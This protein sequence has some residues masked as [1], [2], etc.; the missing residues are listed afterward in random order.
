[1]LTSRARPVL[2]VMTIVTVLTIACQET[3][4]PGGRQGPDPLPPPPPPVLGS[5]I[6]S[7]PTT[8]A[9]PSGSSRSLRLAGELVYI[10]LPPGSFPNG[11]TI[12]VRDRRSGAVAAAPIVLGGADPFPIVGIAGDTLDIQIALGGS[13]DTLAYISLVPLRRPPVLVRTEP[14]VGKRDV[15]L[16]SVLILVFSEPL[17]RQTLTDTTLQLVLASTPISGTIGVAD[18]TGLAITFTPHQPLDPG[19]KYTL[20][21]SV[22][23]RDQSG[24][25]LESPVTLSF[26]TLSGS[27]APVTTFERRSPH[28]V[29][30]HRSRYRLYPGGTFELE[31]ETPSDTVV[32]T[33]HYTQASPTWIGFTFDDTSGTEVGEAY[34]TLLDSAHLAIAY[35]YVM[36]LANLEEGVYASSADSV[37]PPSFPPQAGQIAFVRNGGIYLV[38]SDGSGL[39]QLTSGP[40]DGYPAWSPDGQRIAFTRATETAPHGGYRDI[41]VMN[42]NGTN[43][44]RRT[45]GGYHGAPSWSPDGRWIV[46]SDLNTEDYLTAP[47]GNSTDLFKLPA[48]EDGSGPIN[49]T[50][51]RGW[52]DYPSWSPDGSRI[53]FSSD[54]AAFDF[55]ANVY[56][57]TPDGATPTLVSGGFVE[58]YFPTWLPD[59]QRLAYTNCPWAF[60]YCSSSAL[61]VMKADGTGVIHLAVTSGF[62]RPSWTPDGQTIVFTLYGGIGWVS[63]D[64]RA[65]GIILANGQFPAWRP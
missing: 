17:D 2:C 37:T 25:A 11:V 23:I 49:L 10:S 42:A 36:I 6:V 52:E 64:G 54:W 47:G 9:L 14:P 24:E 48:I 8:P 26:T 59:G 57:T 27:A 5:L 29:P 45:H 19:A 31:Y 40:S 62:N 51:R 41:F 55:V 32:Y 46:F 15:P 56:V 33:G 38:N 7:N 30:S 44:V 3:Q 58:D 35:N 21:A 13:S 18:T 60:N 16:N 61:R 28:R 39:T 63:T 43:V 50:N 53:A 22:G 4:G 1:M 34:G 20:I 65:R 12:A